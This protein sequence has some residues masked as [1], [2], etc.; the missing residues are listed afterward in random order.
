MAGE[1]ETTVQAAQEDI[2]GEEELGLAFPTATLVREMKKYI[3]KDKMI[4]RDVKIGMNKFLADIVKD[5][6]T[7]MN[8]YPYSVID[9]RMFQ[10]ASK[11]YKQVKNLKGEKQRVVAHLNSIIQNC[12]S[13]KRDLDMKFEDQE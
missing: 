12:E 7:K 3:A 6:S 9:H 11:P 4:K 10:E 2:A 5:I 1:T 13:I 8:E